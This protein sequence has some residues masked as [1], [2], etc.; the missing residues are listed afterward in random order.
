MKIKTFSQ[1]KR[2]NGTRFAISD[3]IFHALDESEDSVDL[4]NVFY[5]FMHP[6][7][8]I[9]EGKLFNDSIGAFEKYNY[10]LSKNLDQ[11]DSY[12]WSNFFDVTGLFSSK[13]DKVIT[14][15]QRIK[16]LWNE[17]LSQTDAPIL[18]DL[19]ENDEEIIL[20]ASYLIDFG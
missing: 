12:Y 17:C 13:P 1:W 20:V 7:F 5:I 6:N 18:Y 16:K 19:I 10:L 9:V 15:A 14:T 2:L 8:R 11:K 4:F 3:Y